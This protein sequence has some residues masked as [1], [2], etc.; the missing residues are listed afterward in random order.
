MKHGKTVNIGTVEDFLN[1]VIQNH[2]GKSWTNKEEVLN[3]F[4]NRIKYAMDFIKVN[5]SPQKS[6]MIKVHSNNAPWTEVAKEANLSI[7]TVS[8][9]FYLL[10]AKLAHEEVVFRVLDTGI[11]AFEA[12][13]DFLGKDCPVDFIPEMYISNRR[14]LKTFKRL[15]IQV[16]SNLEKY[17]YQSLVKEYG[18]SDISV[19]FI[20]KLA[21]KYDLIIPER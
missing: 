9:S 14:F 7:S 18:V 8:N 19:N 15:G 2:P 21:E 16:L 17:S 10:I 6:F 1:Y 13:L 12:Y 11:D 4:D 5:P 3:D 20:K